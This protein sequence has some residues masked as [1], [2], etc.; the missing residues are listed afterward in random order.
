MN[1]DHM[2][3][4]K[5]LICHGPNCADGKASALILHDALPE[6]EI[7]FCNYGTP[8]YKALTPE[9]GVLFCDF[10]PYVE[11]EQGPKDPPMT[12]YGRALAQAWVDAGTIVLDHHKGCADLVALFGDRG[13]FADEKAEPA[14]AVPCSRTGRCGP[15]SWCIVASVRVLLCAS[16]PTSRA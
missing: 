5:K 15:V 11:R 3:N 4:I 14:S 6:A 13:V 1:I 7:V 8:E 12:A 16:S 2:K 9:P 10:S